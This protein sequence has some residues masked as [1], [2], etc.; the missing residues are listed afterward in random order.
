MFYKYS[1]FLLIIIHFICFNAYSET[2]I[3]YYKLNNISY[4]FNDN[5]KYIIIN[6]TTNNTK[7]PIKKNNRKNTKK[8]TFILNK[9]SDKKTKYKQSIE[10]S[11]AKHSKNTKK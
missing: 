8:T 5:Q 1:I 11:D 6:N 10:Y 3:T 9:K 7:L 4:K 2:N